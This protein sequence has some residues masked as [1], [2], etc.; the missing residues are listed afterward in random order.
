MYYDSDRLDHLAAAVDAAKAAAQTGRPEG[1]YG[2]GV[3]L[4][5]SAMEEAAVPGAV[6]ALLEGGELTEI[7]ALGSLTADGQ[8]PVTAETIFTVASVS[9][10]VSTVGALRLVDT[11]ELELDE[12]IHRYLTSWE[13]PGRPRVTL[14]QLLGH[15]SGF[16]VSPGGGVAPGQPVPTLLDLLDGRAPAT[17]APVRCEH[18]PGTTFV[19]AG[20]NFVVLQ[21]LIEDVTGKPYAAAAKRLVLEPLGMHGSS[22]DRSFPLT[23][24]RPVA[25]GHLPDGPLDGGW[26]VRA[27]AASGGLWTTAGDLA[28]LALEIR[29]SYLGRPRALLSKELA[30]QMLTPAGDSAFGLGTTAE[31][32][33]DDV[34]FGHG[35]EP[36]G[37]YGGVICRVSSGDGFVL[38]ANATAGKN[39]AQGLAGRLASI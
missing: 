8:R 36:R 15:R 9:K 3:D 21:Q 27:D 12:D 20:A 30:R 6:V 24:G 33:G 17:N 35:G 1:W 18:E 23:S 22:F 14:R 13:V 38:L 26:R 25:L 2:P 37:Y 4:L 19:K 28:T 7:R 34:R 31:V 32:D 39:L 16:T 10:L 5:P 29:R 11:G